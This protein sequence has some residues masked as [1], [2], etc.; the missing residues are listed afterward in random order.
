M[1]PIL[2]TILAAIIS[3]SSSILFGLAANSTDRSLQN[4]YTIFIKHQGKFVNHDLEKSLKRSFLLAQ[5]SIASE[6]RKELVKSSKIIFQGSFR[7][8]KLEYQDEIDWLGHKITSLKKEL[9]KIKELKENQTPIESL[10]EIGLL[11]MSEGN[12]GEKNLKIK[13][14]LLISALNN[15]EFVPNVYRAKITNTLLEQICTYFAFEIKTNQHTKDILQTQLL[16][17]I[18]IRIEDLEK[19]LHNVAKAVPNLSFKLN[20]LAI[21]I[22]QF[23]SNLNWLKNK[24]E[25]VLEA[26]TTISGNI[27]QIK[28]TLDQIFQGKQVTPRT[29][30]AIVVVGNIDEIP[31]QQLEKIKTLIQTASDDVT[32][33][34]IAVKKGSIIFFFESSET[35]L[36]RLEELHRSGELVKLLGIPINEVTSINKNNTLI[37]LSQWLKNNFDG[38]VQAGWETIEELLGQ[39]KLAFRSVATARA[40]QITLG[41]QQ[42]NDIVVLV[43]ELTSTEKQETSLLIKA[44][45]TKNITYLHKDITI[46]VL[47][48][49]EVGQVKAGNE[50]NYLEMEVVG[51]PGEQV[52]IQLSL[53]DFSVT[54]NFVF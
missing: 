41:S 44:Y 32:S 52:S 49:L 40:K 43:I 13:D 11:L 39:K 24:L 22:Q 19:E 15:D 48:K 46:N 36:K 47:Y 17:Q 2:G 33:E 51:L 42:D 35:G 28:A 16:A 38:A 7:L 12:L 1:E 26:I 27:Q 18:N 4:A 23:G 50:C 3:T 10:E 34:F 9:N 21:A 29:I 25:D 53:G 5:Y 30:I 31:P 45:P 6:C 37:N 14:K 20:N 8:S 54:E